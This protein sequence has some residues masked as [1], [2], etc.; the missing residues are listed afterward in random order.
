MVDVSISS[1]RSVDVGEILTLQRA[2]YVGG[3]GTT[4][5]L[6]NRH[7]ARALMPHRARGQPVY[8]SLPVASLAGASIWLCRCQGS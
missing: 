1:V 7:T 5:H 2:A 8:L 6:L 3:D 4:A